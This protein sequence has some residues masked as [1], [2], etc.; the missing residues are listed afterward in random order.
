MINYSRTRRKER[1]KGIKTISNTVKI[2]VDIF[3]G[4]LE[5]G[6]RG[7]LHFYPGTA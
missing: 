5:V 2:L 4:A 1:M 3:D 6:V 7:H